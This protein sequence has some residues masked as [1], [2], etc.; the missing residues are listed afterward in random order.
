MKHILPSISSPHDLKNLSLEQL[1]QLAGE[2]REPFVKLLHHE[3]LILPPI[4]ES[5]NSVWQ[6]IAFLI[7]VAID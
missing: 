5:L 3:Q 2:M 6:F 4:L 1:D 7:L